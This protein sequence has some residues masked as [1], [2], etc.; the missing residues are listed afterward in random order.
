MTTINLHDEIELDWVDVYNKERFE[1]AI[2]VAPGK[3]GT[4][5][6]FVARINRCGTYVNVTCDDDGYLKGYEL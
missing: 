1:S 4:P 3:P 2:I 5:Y 6:C